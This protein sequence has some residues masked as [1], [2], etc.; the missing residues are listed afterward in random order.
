M[1]GLFI[2]YRRSDTLPWAGRLFDSL[3]RTF[4]KGRVFMDINGGIP[5]GSNFEQVLTEAL[6]GCDALL[7]LIGPSWSSCKRADG[8]RRLDVSGDWVRNEIA[9]CLRRGVPV[10][11]VLFGGAP[12]PEEQG[13]PDD[14]R[15]LRKQQEAKVDDLDWHHHV[16]LL[17]QDLQRVTP[18]RP[19][20]PLDEDD[21]ESANTGIRLLSDLV[22]ADRAVA[23]AVGRSKEVIENTYRQVERLEVVKSL[24]DALHTIE[25]ECLRPLQ[26]AGAVSRVRPFKIRFATEARRIR[27][28][29]AAGDL[30]PALRDDMLDALSVAEAA[31]QIAVDSPSDGAR[32]RLLG[33][34]NTVVS[35]IP[36]RLDAA[37]SDTARELN[38]DRLVALMSTVRGTIAA[39]PGD[40]ALAGFLQGIDALG[41]LR[42]E[43]NARV[44]EHGQLQRLDSK[45]R[46]VC[47]GGT[48]AG[49][50]AGEWGR[51][52]LVRGR[53]GVP[54]A[55]EMQAAS[56]DLIALEAEIDAALARGEEAPA[57][58]LVREYFR[59]VGAVFRDVDRAL[60]EFC[61]RLSAVSQPLKT[62]LDLT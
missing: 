39:P 51:V 53:L 1:S 6:A 22:A 45:L 13:L 2:S 25:F 57:F 38:L 9:A 42:D 29:L 33:E 36:S 62:V 41:R 4:G 47:I 28:S 10:V 18:L 16:R 15:A 24:H 49:A 30:N 58:D 35:G 27:D 11:P 46:A 5:R 61:M 23:D 56:G 44:Q 54:V 7:A 43:L 59:A 21:V 32:A 26:E 55:A 19:V 12:L 20:R 34:L 50:L 60:K 14:L 17:I 48:V 40:A 31:F 8:T 37:I 3:T 52:K